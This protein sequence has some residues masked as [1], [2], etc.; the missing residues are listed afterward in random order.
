MYL[1]IILGTARKGRQ[2]EKVAD[3]LLSQAKK[4]GFNS[5]IIDVSD[6]RV[7]ATDNSKSSPQAK[8]LAEKIN[9][10]KGV[11]VVLP[12]YNH[13]YPGELKM[14]IDLLYQEYSGKPV[15][16]CGVSSGKLGGARAIE[17]LKLVVVELGMVLI[18]KSLYF[19]SVKDLFD[20]KGKIKDDSYLKKTKD[21][22]EEL[23]WYIKK[24]EKK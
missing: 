8:K 18:Q 5:E 11:I 6:F 7:D 10:A 4:N 1:P 2:S 15:G 24:Y 23:A 19:S 22:F 16:L 17:Q 3:F 12:E 9:K 13:G 14:M 20:E 21:F